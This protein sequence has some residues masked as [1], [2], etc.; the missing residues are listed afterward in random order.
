MKAS[1]KSTVDWDRFGAADPLVSVVDDLEVPIAILRA[2]FLA[3]GNP[4][5]GDI[6]YERDCLRALEHA[7]NCISS[8]QDAAGIAVSDIR[9]G[10]A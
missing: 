3:L 7:T 4:E 10:C 5:I 6:G 2:V 1:Q 8:V 9:A